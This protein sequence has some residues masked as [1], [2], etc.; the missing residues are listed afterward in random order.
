LEQGNK[1][2]TIAACHFTVVVTVGFISL[3]PACFQHNRHCVTE[4]QISPQVG[5]ATS[6]KTVMNL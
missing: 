4:L 3:L 1:P 2:K 5:E 6:A